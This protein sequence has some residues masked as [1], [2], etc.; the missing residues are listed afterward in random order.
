MQRRGFDWVDAALL[1]GGICL[2]LTVLG[3]FSTE[4]FEAMHEGA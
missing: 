3:G 4:H 2:F 1:P